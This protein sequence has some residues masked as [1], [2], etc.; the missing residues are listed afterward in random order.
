MLVLIIVLVLVFGVGGGYYGNRQWGPGGG[1]GIVGV[2]LVILI[3]CWAAG[4]LR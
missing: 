4:L 1:F 3:I 2:I